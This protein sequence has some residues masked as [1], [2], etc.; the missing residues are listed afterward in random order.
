MTDNTS[1]IRFERSVTRAGDDSSMI[2]TPGELIAYAEALCHRAF[3]PETQIATV[4]N[5]FARNDLSSSD[6]EKLASAAI[7]VGYLIAPGM[8]ADERRVRQQLITAERRR[9]ADHSSRRLRPT[10][11]G[12]QYIQNPRDQRRGCWIKP[13][14][15]I[16]QVEVASLPG[17]G[18]YYEIYEKRVVDTLLGYL[19]R[20]D[21]D[22]DRQ[23]LIDAAKRRGFDLDPASVAATWRQ[24]RETLDEIH[25]AQA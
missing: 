9:R 22:E 17:C 14:V 18:Q 7:K 23:P 3:D 16:E 10:P 13:A 11:P 20:L 19:N 2:D 21:H 25:E 12:P 6:V 8:D 5:N 1:G 24:Y 4:L 15:L